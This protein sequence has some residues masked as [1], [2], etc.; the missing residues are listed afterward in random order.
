M[1][2]VVSRPGF[3]RL[4][5]GLRQPA[6]RDRAERWVW[7]GL[8]LIAVGLLL[9][10]V[11]VLQQR[12]ALQLG[13]QERPLTNTIHELELAYQA[14]LGT[15][16]LSGHVMPSRGVVLENGQPLGPGNA[17]HDDVRKL[18]RGRFSFW[19]DRVY[20]SASDNSDPRA[21]GRAYTAYGPGRLARVVGWLLN[22]LSIGGLLFGLLWCLAAV[23][24]TWT[25]FPS[26]RSLWALA[27]YWRSPVIR[28]LFAAM[29]VVAIA[30]IVTACGFLLVNPVR[31]LQLAQ[32][33]ILTATSAALFVAAGIAAAGIRPGDPRRLVTVIVLL[34]IAVMV[35]WNPQSGTELSPRWLLPPEALSLIP[36]GVLVGVVGRRW[37]GAMPAATTVRHLPLIIVAAFVVLALPGTVAPVAEWWN[38]SGYMDSQMYDI[39]AHRI[40]TGDAVQ[41]NAFVMPLY[42]YGMAALYFVFGHFFFVQQVANIAMQLAFVALLILAAWRLFGDYRAAVL[43]GIMTALTF[44]FRQ[45]VKIT[46]I[47][48]WYVPLVALIIFTWTRYRSRPSLARAAALAVAIGL[49]FNC[50]SQGAFFFA[51]MCL[52]PLVQVGASVRTRLAH[53]AVI[54]AIVAATLLPW[55]LR[56]YVYEGR[57]SPSSDQATVGLLFNDHRVGFYGL[58]WDLYSWQIVLAEYE[59]KYPDKNERFQAIQRD[60]VANTVGDPAWWARAFGWR[61]LSFYGLLPPGVF[62]PTGVIPTDWSVEWRPYVYNRITSLALIATSLLGLVVRPGRDSLFLFGAIFANLAVMLFGSQTEPRISFPVL[63]LHMLLALSAIFPFTRAGAEPVMPR[64]TGSWLTSP[65]L[66][67]TAALVPL[68][69]MAWILVGRP[70]RF[71][72]L[73][74]DAI[75]VAPTAIEAHRL[76]SGDYTDI[77]AAQI[78]AGEVPAPGSRVRIRVRVSNYML[79]PKSAGAVD[80][81][82]RF[83]SEPEREQYFYAPLADGTKVLGITYFGA[84]ADRQIR[85][86]DH[87]TVEGRVL[88]GKPVPL[89]N[90][91]FWLHAE[92]IYK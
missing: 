40:A 69:M 32:G 74:E 57:F 3:R 10:T 33:V 12:G 15:D 11:A 64:R 83:A 24:A 45:F 20:F 89:L 73:M 17:Q 84:V 80:Y 87:V 28:P 77:D 50:R 58:R 35:L 82:P 48:N 41:G 27:T 25:S 56:N 19:G 23:A 76:R 86:Y 46:Q 5:S 68:C 85:E 91:P 55:S 75:V 52:A 70:N 6:A 44:Q 37:R 90:I 71:A 47:E 53:T 2:D 4:L 7:I 39:D 81:L 72:P 8:L 60:A 78:A 36:I 49:A 21:N 14:Q 79:P 42:Q 63:P 59:A 51:W 30:L 38:I 1:S 31:S 13:W 88:D 54:G 29:L 62:A 43:M 92:A 65:Y 66:V 67:T 34:A 26:L 61:S 9:G 16:V 18:G 22:G